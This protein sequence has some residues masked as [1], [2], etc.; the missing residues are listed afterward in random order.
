MLQVLNVND[1]PSFSDSILSKLQANPRDRS[2]WQ[3]L[4][5]PANLA[6][7]EGILVS[8]AVSQTFKD[9]DGGKIGI[10]VL[11]AQRTGRQLI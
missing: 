6:E 4:L 10:C 8:E 5:V 11:R 3:Q 7:N 9:P 2:I 1:P